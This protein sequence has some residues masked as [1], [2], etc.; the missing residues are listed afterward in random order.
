MKRF[1][2]LAVMIVLPTMSIAD[3]FKADYVTINVD[4]IVLMLDF[5]VGIDKVPIDNESVDLSTFTI[6]EENTTYISKMS[7][8]LDH[9]RRISEMNYDMVL[10]LKDDPLAIPWMSS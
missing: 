6:T 3:Q 5:D 9:R 10:S 7:K 4:P 8:W 2:L 1:I